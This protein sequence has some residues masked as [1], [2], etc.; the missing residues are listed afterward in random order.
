MPHLCERVFYLKKWNLLKRQL[1]S[2]VLFQSEFDAMR[3]VCAILFGVYGDRQ[4][5]HMYLGVQCDGGGL[6]LDLW[7]RKKVYFSL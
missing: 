7:R 4:V 1:L 2:Y 5:Q 3:E 6:S